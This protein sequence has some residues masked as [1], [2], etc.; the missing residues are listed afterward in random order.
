MTIRELLEKIK[1]DYENRGMWI[2]D[3]ATELHAPYETIRAIIVSLGYFRGKKIRMVSLGTLLNDN[4]I[5]SSLEKIAIN[6]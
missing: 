6:L 2:S 4:Y 3:I 1:E 5:R